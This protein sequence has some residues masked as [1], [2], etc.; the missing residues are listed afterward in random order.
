LIAPI[1]VDPDQTSSTMAGYALL[2]VA[3]GHEAGASGQ[4]K[5]LT[6]KAQPD[7]KGQ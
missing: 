5:A 1:T 3:A 6:P 2:P 4:I 7:P